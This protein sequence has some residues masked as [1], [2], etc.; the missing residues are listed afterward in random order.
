MK[1]LKYFGKTDDFN[2]S[3]ES[4]PKTSISYVK[5][6]EKLIYK[7]DAIDLSLRDIYG[8]PIKRTTANCYVISE[9]G[10]YKFPLVYGNAIKSGK[11][12]WE[13]F[14]IS[15]D[16]TTTPTP[17]PPTLP[18][19]TTTTTT[20]VPP[21][22][23]DLTPSNKIGI[24]ENHLGDQ[25]VD[26]YIYEN[27]DCIPVS[28]E[29]S[30]CDEDRVI[31]KISCNGKEIYFN[32][33]RVPEVGANG[34]ISV[35]DSSGVIMWSWHIWLWKDSL[36]TK[37][38]SGEDEDE[39]GVLRSFSYDIL[40]VNLA[41]KW[42]SEKES[43]NNWT[44]QWGRHNPML[45]T[46]TYDNPDET[47]KN[48]GIR[49][50]SVI[51]SRNSF[52][53]DYSILIKNPQTLYINR[54]KSINLIETLYYINRW[55]TN[56][57]KTTDEDNSPFEIIDIEYTKKTIYDPCPAGF[58]VPS[59]RLFKFFSNVLQ[60]KKNNLYVFSND[61]EFPKISSKSFLYKEVVG[62]FFTNN[63]YW[64]SSTN[65]EKSSKA[66]SYNL[67]EV[68][69]N[70]YDSTSNYNEKDVCIYSIRPMKEKD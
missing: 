16:T 44:Y 14:G 33:D 46:E 61:I 26:P 60:K 70:F 38:V 21:D 11:I 47:H 2:E 20:T 57:R 67:S 68:Q 23:P 24:F 7:M 9:P 51:N 6:T 66:D 49:E 64:T 15:L 5:D 4:I 36:E 69:W 18:P 65:L 40:P 22:T 35:L 1:Y 31:S 56:I 27:S 34:I 62:D 45:L 42:D 41:S 43:L 59:E 53:Q 3:L 50:Y 63:G 32:V 52:P 58:C 29:L 17:F 54:N 8:N 37:N 10:Y 55:T 48:Y 30:L 13:A 25:I 39:L 19:T 12:N 28:A